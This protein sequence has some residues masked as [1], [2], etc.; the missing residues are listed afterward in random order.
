MAERDAKYR[1]S[2]SQRKRDMLALQALGERL[3]DLS[4]EQVARLDLPRDLDEAVAFYHTLKNKEARRRHTQFIGV[5]M[6]K[7]DPAPIRQALETLDQAHFQ[8]MEEFHQLEA[9]R[10]ALLDGDNE[11]QAEVVRRFDL[12]PG[13]VKQMA[14]RAAAEK[15]AGKP[16]REGRALFRLLRRGLE[17]EQ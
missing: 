5:I 17:K 8:H 6:R 14:E 1:P 15:A 11:V 7:I 2:K 16:S 3:L 12:N 13:Q 9:W 4:P 10:D